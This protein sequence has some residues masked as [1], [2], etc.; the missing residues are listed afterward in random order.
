MNGPSHLSNG[1]VVSGGG[2]ILTQETAIYIGIFSPVGHLGGSM[3]WPS[4]LDDVAGEIKSEALGVWD[5]WEFVASEGSHPGGAP[6]IIVQQ[7]KRGNS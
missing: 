4:L 7:F 1:L 5:V 3:L 6:E 2:V